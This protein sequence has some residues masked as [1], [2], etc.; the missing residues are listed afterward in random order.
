[1]D[2]HPSPPLITQGEASYSP[3]WVTP[4]SLRAIDAELRK[5]PLEHITWVLEDDEGEHSSDD[6][7]TLL[8]Q[9]AWTRVGA[10][11]VVA[12]LTRW[13]GE[14]RE[15]G[16]AA[17]DLRCASHTLRMWWS[18]NDAADVLAVQERAARVGEVIE[19]L[20]ES[21]PSFRFVLSLDERAD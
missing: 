6:L 14:M 1:M 9:V 18:A 2:E 5:D 15:N 4:E 3:R 7:N 13:E 11:A 19:A 12:T 17:V 20:P 16:Y 8:A 10:L 21:G